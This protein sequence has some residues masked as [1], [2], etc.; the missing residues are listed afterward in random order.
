MGFLGG[1]PGSGADHGIYLYVQ[2]AESGEKIRVRINPDNDLAQHFDAE[3]GDNP[4]HYTCA[5]EV[6]G[7]ESLS[8]VELD[9]EFDGRRRLVGQSRS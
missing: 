4:T 9:L 3:G 8:K 2:V 5:K 1:G 7:N 6:I